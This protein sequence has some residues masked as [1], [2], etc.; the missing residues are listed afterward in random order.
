[1][2]AAWQF[3]EFPEAICVISQNMLILL[4]LA[5][6]LT[7]YFIEE[8]GNPF[9]G[10][11]GDGKQ[12]Q[13]ALFEPWGDLRQIFPNFRQVDLVDDDD[14]PFPRQFRIFL[15]LQEARQQA[16]RSDC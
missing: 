1:M 8:R 14:L 2:G 13:T 7:G 5:P 15:S 9:A 10:H 12:F 6:Q 11:S 3:P 4:G 16:S